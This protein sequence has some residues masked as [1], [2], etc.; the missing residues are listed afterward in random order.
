[1]LGLRAR[2]RGGI[3]AAEARTREEIALKHA[4]GE[5]PPARELPP[6]VIAVPIVPPELRI[7]E[8]APEV[9]PAIEVRSD[10][11]APGL[12]IDALSDN[13]APPL[14][15]V[16]PANVVTI[17]V[18]GD[19]GT[20]TVC[21]LLRDALANWGFSFEGPDDLKSLRWRHA[22]DRHLSRDLRIVIKREFTEPEG[23]DGR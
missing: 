3:N 1:M 22:V 2:A 19:D 8:T 23:N 6:S 16:T 20:T 21:H 11:P 18:S 5:L 4:R 9:A 10:D 14:T 12:Q 17:T 7:V 13:P 15:R